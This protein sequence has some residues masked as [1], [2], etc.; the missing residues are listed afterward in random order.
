[1]ARRR[2]EAGCFRVDPKIKGVSLVKDGKI[3]DGPRLNGWSVLPSAVGIEAYAN[4][5]WD[6]VTIDM[7]HGWWD[8]AGAVTALAILQG[9]SIPSFVRVPVNEPGVIGR[10]LDA[11]AGGVICPMINSAEDA[12]RLVRNALYPPLGERS[13]GPVRG[14][15]FP[16]AAGNVQERANQHLVLFPQIETRAAVDNAEAIMDTPGISGIYVGPGDLGLSMGL[17][18]ML[19]REEPDLLRIYEGLVAAAKVRGQIA[20]IHNHSAEYGRRMIELGFD[21][22][23]VGSDLGH[24]LANGLADVRRFAGTPE[25]PARGAY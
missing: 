11:G 22:V 10:V 3:K 24:M 4:L 5:G 15:P 17:P 20:G 7:Q 14:A 23:T 8:Y 16:P 18:A 19:D 6:S 2:G 13:S 25:S 12:R 1:M 21:F 9:A